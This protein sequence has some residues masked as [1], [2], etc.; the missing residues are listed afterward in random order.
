MGLAEVE[1]REA[2]LRDG[3]IAAVLPRAGT[4]EGRQ[5]RRWLVQVLV[6][7]RV[8][9]EEAAA[10]MLYAERPPALAALAPDSAALLGLGSVAADVLTRYPLARKVFA[11]ITADVAVSEEDVARYWAANPEAFREPER[12][13]VR[14]ALGDV[15]LD[16]RPARVV[17][18]GELS[19]ALGEAVFAAAPGETVGPLSDAIGRH[20]VLVLEVR[21]ARVRGL[22]EAGAEIGRRLLLGARRRAFT[23][24]LDRRLADRVTL[25]EGFEHPGDPRQP[26]NT[27]RH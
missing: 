20:T 9:R 6:T 21:P 19:G 7:E 11:A 26:D 2:E 1:R 25:V 5:L 18:R 13:V 22:D 15:P 12:R 4:S 27:H 8:V 14:H 16:S 24:W 3:P 17:R 23:A 10:R